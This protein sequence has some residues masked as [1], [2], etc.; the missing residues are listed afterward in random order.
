MT[1]TAQIVANGRTS[2][3]FFNA[4]SVFILSEARRVIL[5]MPLTSASSRILMDINPALSA[6]F[7]V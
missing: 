6:L 4:K 2:Q 3:I 5:R 7:L 1:E